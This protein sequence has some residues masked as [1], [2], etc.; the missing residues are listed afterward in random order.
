VSSNKGVLDLVAAGDIDA[1]QAVRQAGRDIGEVLAHCVSVLNPSMIIIG[2]SLSHA[3]RHLLAGVRE[4]V[5]AQAMPFST[6]QLEIVRANAPD[7]A[8]I[9]GA[10]A[11]AIDRLLTPTPPS[12][13]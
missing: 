11:L 3:G 6:Q 5:H 8:A 4:V 12:M 10:A 2:G 1:I 7:L 13:L 9:T